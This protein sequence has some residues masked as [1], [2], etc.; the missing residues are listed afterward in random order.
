[1]MTKL[2]IAVFV[3]LAMLLGCSAATVS[4]EDTTTDTAVVA[5][6]EPVDGPLQM[7]SA[8]EFQTK[9]ESQLGKVVLLDMWAT[10]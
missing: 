4:T 7:M 9:M 10:W 5:V 3:P 2:Q 1:M 8:S 6:G